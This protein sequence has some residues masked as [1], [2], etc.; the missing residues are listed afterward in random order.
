[1]S[2]CDPSIFRAYTSAAELKGRGFIEF[3]P[4]DWR[5]RPSLRNE[6]SVYVAS[7][8]M[9]PFVWLIGKATPSFRLH[10]PTGLRVA[11]LS[12]LLTAFERFGAGLVHARTAAEL[13]RLNAGVIVEQDTA[14]SAR[15]HLIRSVAAF[16]EVIWRAQ[17]RRDGCLWVLA[18]PGGIS[19]PG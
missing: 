15:A 8:G 9:G 7:G 14:A 11:Q 16:E 18:C 2:I 4:G 13:K 10:G 17:A 6:D 19:V 12:P 1:M 3:C 5:T